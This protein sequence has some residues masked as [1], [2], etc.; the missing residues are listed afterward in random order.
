MPATDTV[1]ASQI[2]AALE[3]L[4]H[5]TL[6]VMCFAEAERLPFLPAFAHPVEARIDFSASYAGHLQMEVEPAAAH[7]LTAA[8]LGLEPSHPSLVLHTRDAVHELARVLCGRLVTSLD[9]TAPFETTPTAI[10]GSVGGGETIRQAFRLSTGTL[11]ITLQ[12]S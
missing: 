1:S 7:A 10:G 3:G 6:E 4:V 12:M 2:D 5:H 9:P 11:R 8:F